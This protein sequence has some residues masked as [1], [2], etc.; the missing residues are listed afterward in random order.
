MSI[1]TKKELRR[2]SS[3]IHNIG[4]T[5]RM[6]S[7]NFYVFLYLHVLHILHQQNF[8]TNKFYKRINNV[9]IATNK[10]LL[11]F[12]LP[13]LWRALHCALNTALKYETDVMKNAWEYNK[14]QWL[15]IRSTPGWSMFERFTTQIDRTEFVLGN[16]LSPPSALPRKSHT[17]EKKPTNFLIRR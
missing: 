5:A 4:E 3:T 11:F 7:F 10:M 16:S 2:G 1:E 8:Q 13:L 14:I 15:C 6:L 17:A 12:F 9:L